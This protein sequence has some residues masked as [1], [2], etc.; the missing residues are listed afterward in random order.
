MQRFKTYTHFQRFMLGVICGL[1]PVSCLLFG[2]L[3]QWRGVNFD[4][5]FVSI[6]AT[7][8]SNAGSLMVIALG[9]CAFFLLTYQGYGRGEKWYDLGDYYAQVAGV[10]A[11]LVVVCPC[12]AEGSGAFLGLLALPSRISS[13]IH[14]VSA[15]V[16][17]GV[18]ALMI[19]TQFTKGN[20]R[21]RNR[22][23]RICGWIMVVAMGAVGVTMLI[24]NAPAWLTMVYEVIMLE[25]FATAW[26]VKSGAA[27]LKV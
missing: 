9:L 20:H 27:K 17:F 18:F 7:Y 26:I 2:L 13:A 6:S 25:A 16:L 15:A 10:A 19:L 24:P 3:G 22:L 11:L 23:Y 21:L 1:L 8:F 5:W 14:D 12:D 4:N